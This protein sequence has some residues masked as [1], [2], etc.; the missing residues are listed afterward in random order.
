MTGA[1]DNGGGS[2]SKQQHQE[3]EDRAFENRRTGRDDEGGDRSELSGLTGDTDQQWRENRFPWATFRA[4]CA[5]LLVNF[6]QGMLIAYT[7]PALDT[8]LGIPNLKE[9]GNKTIPQA[10][11]PPDKVLFS[12]ARWAENTGNVIDSPH[13][14][15][16]VNRDSSDFASFLNLGAM[17]GAVLAGP[18]I[19]A[20]GRRTCNVLACIP[21]MLCSM[22]IGITHSVKCV[23]V[24]RLLMGF[25]VGW[26]SVSVPVYIAEISPA[27][28]RGAFSFG[29]SVAIMLG[30]LCVNLLG[31]HAL[32]ISGEPGVPCSLYPTRFPVFPCDTEGKYFCD[33]RTLSFLIIIPAGLGMIGCLLSPESPSWLLYHKSYDAALKSLKRLRQD[34]PAKKEI[35]MLRGMEHVQKP[36]M[37]ELLKKLGTGNL[38][39]LFVCMC[40][41]AFYQWTG[42]YGLVFF[43]DSILEDAGIKKSVTSNWTETITAVQIVTTTL[44]CLVVDKHFGRRPL[45]MLSCVVTG[46]GAFIMAGC[47]HNCNAADDGT[48]T[49]KTDT[50]KHT[51]LTGIFVYQ[52]GFSIGMGS[53]PWLLAAEFFPYDLRNL[54]ASICCAL[55]WGCSYAITKILSPCG[56]DCVP[57]LVKAIKIDGVWFL[58]AS[59]C[60][61]AAGFT[62]LLVPET[63][64]K[65]LD[66]IAQT[67]D[68]ALSD[69]R[70]TIRN[71]RP[72]GL[73]LCGFCSQ[74]CCNCGGRED[75]EYDE[76]P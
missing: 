70:T 32:K 35:K 15:H 42:L 30:I 1:F 57:T 71:E 51:F 5:A 8:M 67:F 52:I 64:G 33:W 62:F 41:H 26:S 9:V 28:Y 43:E 74:K 29:V 2:G 55:N 50:L 38:R 54:S 72:M 17:I 76:A 37:L 20:L 7:S 46:I 56:Q 60:V 68:D 24:A 36:P 4:T 63:K 39:P 14:W 40:L 22:W 25:A 58:F 66:D 16:G 73:R 75:Y 47:F 23:L 10:Y 44:T 53:I 65:P 13:A 45:L 18:M 12:D 49:K 27:R 31:G 61:F 19:E 59:V 3:E 48:C 69:D 34:L 6:T 21:F 11:P